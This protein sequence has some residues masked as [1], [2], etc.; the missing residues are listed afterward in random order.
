MSADSPEPST[1]D[2]EQLEELCCYLYINSVKELHDA[3][4]DRA[5]EWGLSPLLLS[6]L[7]TENM[8]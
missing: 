2:R 8:E 5:M 1:P 7:C 4:V 3:V 6:M